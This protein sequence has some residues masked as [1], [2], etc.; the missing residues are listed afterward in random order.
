MLSV[1]LSMLGSVDCRLT[2]IMRLIK[3]TSTLMFLN[4]RNAQGKV[5]RE[6]SLDGCCR[7]KSVLHSQT[8]ITNMSMF[9][10]WSSTNST[11]SS[12]NYSC[13]CLVCEK[14]PRNYFR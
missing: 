12:I 14:P 8:V 11:N 2:P 9:K 10:V 3:G 7:Q 13:I 1:F 6:S 4:A 5:Y